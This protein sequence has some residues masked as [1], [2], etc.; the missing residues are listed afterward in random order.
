LTQWSRTSKTPCVD[1]LESFINLLE[2]YLLRRKGRDHVVDAVGDDVAQ[3]MIR[4]LIARLFDVLVG[5]R[6][7]GMVMPCAPWMMSSGPA[8]SLP[9]SMEDSIP[10]LG[11]YIWGRSKTVVGGA[12]DT[13]PT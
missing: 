3:R 1:R 13:A 5:Q 9:P 2:P 8:K 10:M 7:S 4:E 12:M 11:P 6:A